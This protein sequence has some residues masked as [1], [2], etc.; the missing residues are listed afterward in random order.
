ML[1]ST[2]TQSGY[3][4]SCDN[5]DI[6]RQH[7]GD[8]EFKFIR[9]NKY[10]G[11]VITPFFKCLKN[12][13]IESNKEKSYAIP[14]DANGVF[15]LPK[16]AFSSDGYIAIAFALARNDEVIQTD[17]IVYKIIAS[18]GDGDYL[19]DK[20]NWQQVVIQ[21]CEDWTNSNIKPDLDKMKVE[22]QKCID[23]AKRQQDKAV[24]QQKS[25]DN[26]FTELNKLETTVNKN[27][28]ERQN[29]EAKRKTDTANAIKNCNDK[30]NEI[31]DKLLNG[32]FVGE[33]GATPNL[34]IGNVNVGT[35]AVTLRGTKENPIMDIKLPSAGDL[36]GYY[37]KT[38]I[39][40]FLTGHLKPK[41]VVTPCGGL[42]DKPSVLPD[43]RVWGISYLQL[44]RGEL[45]YSAPAF[46]PKGRYLFRTNS[47]TPN[48]TE[49]EN[50]YHIAWISNNN[51]INSKKIQVSVNETEFEMNEDCKEFR[52]YKTYP[53]STYDGGMLSIEYAQVIYKDTYNSICSWAGAEF[54]N[55]A[56]IKMYGDGTVTSAKVQSGQY[57]IDTISGYRQFA[58]VA[59][60][61]GALWLGGGV[62]DDVCIRTPSIDMRPKWLYG[63]YSSST[64]KEI[65]VLDD[66]AKIIELND[67]IT[68]LN[69][70]GEGELSIPIPSPP[71]NYRIIGVSFGNDV[72]GYEPIYHHSSGATFSLKAT[73]Y[74][75]GTKEY[76]VSLKARK[77]AGNISSN[78]YTSVK[79]LL[80]ERK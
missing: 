38:Q 23:E 48:V 63:N 19:D 79:V 2:I 74:T 18:A 30:V 14:I 60:S 52:I 24:E 40:T 56:P 80:L 72:G 31:N 75:Q 46:Y 65:A 25:I 51:T 17:P 22:I 12:R 15:R 62:W 21:L 50:Y 73:F 9:D 32:D 43:T 7:S 41:S 3:N 61:G 70:T 11:Y 57:E 54:P 47:V 66:I 13:F 1:I 16:K 69:T 5:D 59:G 36:S 67:I 71:A 45:Y 33:T 44:V 68:I 76:F 39:D 58:G 53:S 42:G 49:D 55:S 26:K 6:P 64:V 29:N 4:L 10:N 78:V 20:P 37:D 8:T 35:P 34:Q 28:T 27:E 77:I